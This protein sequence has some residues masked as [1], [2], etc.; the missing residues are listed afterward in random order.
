MHLPLIIIIMQR[1]TGHKD[2]ERR[3]KDY[4]FYIIMIHNVLTLPVKFEAN[5]PNRPT[6]F[7]SRT[8]LRC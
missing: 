3:R 7:F 6:S 5:V 4:V 1:L 8:R 2:D